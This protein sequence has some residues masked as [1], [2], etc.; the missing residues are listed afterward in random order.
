MSR[1][2]PPYLVPQ[3]RRPSNAAFVNGIRKEVDGWRAQG[4]PG[5]TVTTRRLLQHWFE[6][7]HERGGQEW[8]YYFCQREAIET[9]IFLYEIRRLRRL[10]D[11]AREYNPR[12]A[13]RPTEDRYAR[14]L[15]KMA[16]G[17][18]KTKVMSLAVVWSYFNAIHHPEIGLPENFL[19]IAPNVIVYERLVDDF[20]GGRVFR[21]D[22][23][24]P[25]E[26]APEWQFTVVL[27]DDPGEP[28]TRGALFLSNVQQLY[29]HENSNDDLPE[30]V[31]GVMP[32][33]VRTD[34]TS[35][36]ERRARFIERGSL[37]VLND[38]GHH[39]H[40]EDLEWAKLIEGLHDA[41]R[42]RGYGGIAGQL[43]FTAT[44]RHHNGALFREIVV[45]Y[46]IADA[47]EDGIVK[48]P[49]IG[50]LRGDLEYQS[51]DASVRYRDRI[52]AGVEK[53][54]QFNAELSKAEQKPVLFVMAENTAAADQ[55]ALYLETLP[56]FTGRVLSIHTN[57]RGEIVEG[58]TKAKQQEIEQLRQ[59]ARRVDSNDNPYT[60]I[61]SVL[62]LREGWDV[63][64]V[65]VI[66]PL[67]AY[68]SKAQ[69]LPEQTLGRGLRRMT[70]P[71][72]GDIHEQLVVIE[73][74]AF[75]N[76]WKT[77]LAEEGLDIQ[78]VPVELVR[79]T[80]RTVAVDKTKL[81]FD[82]E[83]PVLTPALVRSVARL[84]QIRFEDLDVP[85]FPLP[86]PQA[87]RE[88]VIQYTGR[89][90]F[91]WEIV[92]E[93][94]FEREFPVEPS[95][96]LSALV[97]LVEKETRITGQFARIAPL[98]KRCIEQRL[99]GAPVSMEHEVVIRVLNRPDVK[100]ALFEALVRA[101]NA[102]S[103][104][105]QKVALAPE[106]IR[107]SATNAFTTTRDCLEGGKTVFNL[108]P[109][110][111]QLEKD[112]AG[113]LEEAED[114]LAYVK[115]ETALHF[116]IEYQGFAGGLRR[117]RPDFVV[118]TP[119]GMFVVETKGQ[120]D[121]EVERKD[122]RARWWCVDASNLTGQTWDFLK[123]PEGVFRG[124][125]VRDFAELE[126]LLAPGAPIREVQPRIT[127]D[128][129]VLGGEPI[130]R[131]T[132][133]AVRHIVLTER[134]SGSVEG[135]LDSYP[136]LTRE[137]VEEALAF[138]E[139]HQAEIDEHIQA[140]NADD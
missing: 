19:L 119:G 131:G 57:V 105:E 115:N 73:H 63:R 70:L 76:F 45:D 38:E 20:G 108:V 92:E 110:D 117:Y 78:W 81:Q 112:F 94:E 7:D 42:A 85:T 121:L 53:W 135:V 103:I 39:L 64:N 84:D 111:S 36:F 127:R 138:Y 51:D 50:E 74:Q 107:P 10:S 22:P 49:L 113:F 52:N 114:V 128:P 66:V 79:P 61:V 80:T 89:H 8:H 33:P 6:T 14:Y 72:S 35:G 106:W 2:L 93:A 13:V 9:L 109:C 15:F 37:M 67:R 26:W 125:Q 62:M 23:L 3:Q 133:L 137:D 82:I 87:L 97:R 59:A 16:T 44:P 123:V 129:L 96:Y 17:S 21:A 55:I 90:M 101:I 43:D 118:R 11:L 130:V 41:L 58:R 134:E 1:L 60:A 77:E 126:R 48:T 29:G 4:Y 68:S 91:T 32:P 28:A 65:V 116:D 132:R 25:P 102:V 99:F 88:D 83:I 18:G 56:D 86:E 124:Y 136:T 46:P 95:G 5:A 100:K 27:R 12:I 40:N 31:A 75:K 120:E 98:A 139:V 104:E 140:N 34:A 24:V 54:R 30:A 122:R 69:I 71:A 47:V